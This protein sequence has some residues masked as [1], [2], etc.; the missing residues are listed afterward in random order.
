MYLGPVPEYLLVNSAARRFFTAAGVEGKFLSSFLYLLTQRSGFESAFRFKF[1]RPFSLLLDAAL[2]KTTA[3]KQCDDHLHL[4]VFFTPRLEH[5]YFSADLRLKYSY[6]YFKIIEKS[7]LYLLTSIDLIV[8]YR[9]SKCKNMF[10]KKSQSRK[11]QYHY[12][13][14]VPHG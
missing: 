10:S 2:K 14:K 8:F 12:S 11:F 7:T 1:F 13:Y 4:I 9:S 5:S 6:D 3:K